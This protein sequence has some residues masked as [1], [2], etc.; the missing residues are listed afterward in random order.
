MAKVIKQPNRQDI[1]SLIVN[2]SGVTAAAL[3][4]L[5]AGGDMTP[6]VVFAPADSGVA[7]AAIDMPVGAIVVGGYL[8]PDV[9]MDAGATDTLSLGDAVSATRYLNGADVHALTKVDLALT[10]YQHTAASNT[11]KLTWTGGTPANLSAGSGRI[12]INYIV[13]GRSESTQ[14]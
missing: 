1:L 14:G 8:K 2:Y 12:I 10:G 11:L 5:V 6:G 4:A 3:A 9:V 7:I 13:A